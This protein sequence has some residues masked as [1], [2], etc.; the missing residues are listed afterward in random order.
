[1]P[2]YNSRCV[3]REYCAGVIRGTIFSIPNENLHEPDNDPNLTDYELTN[4]IIQ[5]TK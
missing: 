1:M 3:T 5:K 4:I 2:D